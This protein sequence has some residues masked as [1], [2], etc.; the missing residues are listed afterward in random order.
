MFLGMARPK[1]HRN[2]EPVL[3]DLQAGFSAFVCGVIEP[4]GPRGKLALVY[5]VVACRLLPPENFPAVV[6]ALPVPPPN[7][8]G[9]RVHGVPNQQA[10]SV[11][12]HQGAGSP[13]SE[14]YNIASGTA[15]RSVPCERLKRWLPGT[16][17]C[18]SSYK[19]LALGGG[20]IRGDPR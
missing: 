2:D 13:L 17:H 16:D 12:D 9:L 14:V 20:H 4:D 8:E 1:T 15:G 7:S 11:W 5:C 18:L 6:V 3:F 10:A 19:H